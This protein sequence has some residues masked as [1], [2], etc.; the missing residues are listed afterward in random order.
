MMLPPIKFIATTAGAVL[1]AEA[2]DIDAIRF[3]RQFDKPAPAAMM[4][5]RLEY[6]SYLAYLAVKRVHKLDVEFDDWV[7]ALDD[8]DVEMPGEELANPLPDTTPSTGS[9]PS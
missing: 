2:R 9:P 8:L 7:E 5:G 3:E 4:E 1:E 6:M